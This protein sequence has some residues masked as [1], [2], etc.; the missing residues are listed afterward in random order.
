MAHLSLIKSWGWQTK[1]KST[2]VHLQKVT[3]MKSSTMLNS[4]QQDQHLL[5]PVSENAPLELSKATN[6]TVPSLHSMHSLTLPTCSLT[7]GKQSIRWR[8]LNLDSTGSPCFE[9]SAVT[10]S[11]SLALIALKIASSS[12]SVIPAWT[13][14]SWGKATTQNFG[15]AQ[16]VMGHAEPACNINNTL[17]TNK[18]I[19]WAQNGA[20]MQIYW[21]WGRDHGTASMVNKGLCKVNFTLHCLLVCFFAAS[22]SEDEDVDTTFNTKFKALQNILAIS[23]WLLAYITSTRL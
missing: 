13:S 4:C 3:W 18:T 6:S 8:L 14:N 16:S 20:T 10:A 11:I 22:S 21:K 15:T 7:W 5:N 19:I 23:S 12:T 9:I 1:F 17:Q 2:V